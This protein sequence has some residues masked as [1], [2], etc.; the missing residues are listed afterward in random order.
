MS[1][2]RNIPL[3][4]D[5][6]SNSQPSILGNFQA[7]DSGT[8]G[9]GIGFARNHVTMTDATNGG[10]HNRIDFYQALTSPTITG[11]VA[12][13]YPKTVTNIELFYKNTT[14]DM[15]ITNSLLTASSG[16]GMLPGGLQIRTGIVSG[17]SANNSAQTIT[18]GLAFPTATIVVMTTARGSDYTHPVQTSGTNKSFF[19]ATCNNGGTV[20][21]NYVAIGY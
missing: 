2:N 18:Y 5:L 19:L 17:M 1:Y 6:I 4:T 21:F 8:T 12:S 9:T 16:Q 14:Q 15:Q 11:F 10:L 13:E 20:N 3:S 7:I